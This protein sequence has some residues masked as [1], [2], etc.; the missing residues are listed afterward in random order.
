MKRRSVA[1]KLLGVVLLAALLI[2]AMG[3]YHQTQAAPAK[4]VKI[5]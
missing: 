2:G 5:G 1:V 3:S 4:H